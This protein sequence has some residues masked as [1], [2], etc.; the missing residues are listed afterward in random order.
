MLILLI[1][2]TA[3]TITN[4]MDKEDHTST[5]VGFCGAQI[6]SK[7]IVFSILV[8]HFRD[9]SLV[10]FKQAPMGLVCNLLESFY[11][12]KKGIIAKCLLSQ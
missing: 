4:I 3:M 9:E 6:L 12:F 10:C 2:R 1:R 8:M 11:I 7:T 5:N